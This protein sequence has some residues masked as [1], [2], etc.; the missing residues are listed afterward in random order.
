MN[1]TITSKQATPMT[2]TT[3]EKSIPRKSVL[4]LSLREDK[5]DFNQ[6]HMDPEINLEK[7]PQAVTMP[8]EQPKNPT[9][10]KPKGKNKILPRK[11]CET[12]PAK[13]RLRKPSGM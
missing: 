12:K 3:L 4:H 6:S 11:F 10:A 8:K 1:C 9:P 7:D 13:P 2:P 5:D